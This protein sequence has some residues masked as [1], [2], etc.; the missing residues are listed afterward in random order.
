MATFLTVMQRAQSQALVQ[1][2][3]P[4]LDKMEAL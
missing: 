4:L 2:S 3:A 1:L